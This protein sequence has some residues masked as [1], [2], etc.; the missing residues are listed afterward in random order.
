MAALT[1]A[2]WPRA[3]L[4]VYLSFTRLLRTRNRRAWTSWS[5]NRRQQT[6]CFFWKG[7]REARRD[8]IWS[9]SWAW[10]LCPIRFTQNTTRVRERASDM[11]ACNTSF[12]FTDEL[13]PT[14]HGTTA[15]SSAVAMFLELCAGQVENGPPPSSFFQ[16][17]Q[18]SV[19]ARLQNSG[20]SGGWTRAATRQEMMPCMSPW[21]Y[22]W[23]HTRISPSSQLRTGGSIC[24]R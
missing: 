8:A 10:G 2:Y 4:Y 9:G 22:S 15:A 21:R 3:F 23:I 11:D 13:K 14:C 17:S 19:L 6:H 24:R 16:A 12:T 5:C 20:P 7:S 1:S 18:F